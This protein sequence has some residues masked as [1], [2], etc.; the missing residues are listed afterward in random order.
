MSLSLF[1]QCSSS[2]SLEE[3]NYG[4]ALVK[5]IANLA[6]CC[7]Y[8]G[9]LTRREAEEKLSN[10]PD[11]SFLIRDSSTD[12]YLFCISFR[13]IGHT[14]H[15]H[16]DHITGYYSLFNTARYTSIAELVDHAIKASQDSL[17]CY[18]KPRDN[19]CPRFPVRLL[20]P[21]SR[22]TQVRSLQH[23]CRFVIRQ[24]TSISNISRLPIPVSLQNYLK[25]G[26]Y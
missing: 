19:A 23:L 1:Q 10:L 2:L 15:S 16:I 24:K 11:G 21:V 8:W 14:L 18:T 7:W 6:N 9:P 17:Y 4:N 20:H 25:Q 5:E 13:S 22:F 26:H 12:K 3:G